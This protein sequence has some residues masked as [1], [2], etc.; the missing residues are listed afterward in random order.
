[1]EEYPFTVRYYVYNAEENENSFVAGFVRF[2]LSDEGQS[3]VEKNGFI[4]QKIELSGKFM[5]SHAPM[6]YKEL[7]QRADRVAVNLRLRLESTELDSRSARDIE[8][9]SSMVSSEIK[10]ARSI[11]L[12]GFSNNM[13]DASAEELVARKLLEKV[14]KEFSMHGIKVKASLVLRSIIPIADDND[15]RGREK[16]RRVEVWLQ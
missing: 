8:R 7:A 1:M 11:I 14:E 13:G 6:E 4:S 15:P 16:N 5:L 3:V 9:I 12:V 10:K 2:A